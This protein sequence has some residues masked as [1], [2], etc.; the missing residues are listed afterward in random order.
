MRRRAAGFRHS[1]MRRMFAVF[2]LTVVPILL[3]CLAV[4]HQGATSPG[5]AG[6]A[7]WT[8]NRTTCWKRST[9]S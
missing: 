7:W 9:G 8:R 3:G 4:Y 5:G 2:L 6:C 1:L